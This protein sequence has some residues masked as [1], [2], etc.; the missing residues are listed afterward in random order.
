MGKPVCCCAAAENKNSNMIPEQNCF[1]A[2]SPPI[3][4]ELVLVVFADLAEL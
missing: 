2:L 3:L 1:V 4:I